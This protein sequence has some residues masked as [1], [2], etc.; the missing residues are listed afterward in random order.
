MLSWGQ[1]RVIILWDISDK[2]SFTRYALQD[3][4]VTGDI[5]GTRILD[6]GKRVIVR[7]TKCLS[8]FNLESKDKTVVIQETNQNDGSGV[9]L[10][11]EG[12]RA[13]CW[14]KDRSNLVLWDLSNGDS[15]TNHV[16]FNGHSR[17][18]MGLQL[19][20]GGKKL[21]SYSSHDVILWTETG[22][23]IWSLKFQYDLLFLNAVRGF[24]GEG[25]KLTKVCVGQEAGGV[26]LFTTKV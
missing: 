21:L 18:V 5:I 3:H 12:K 20:E 26:A 25:D 14:S 23:I 4:Q 7:T 22:S 15:K 16:S 13:L 11:S 2:K 24:S 10:L 6:E 9:E 1:D 19:F 17:G 8:L